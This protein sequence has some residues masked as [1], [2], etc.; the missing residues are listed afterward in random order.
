MWIYIDYEVW[1]DFLE[2]METLSSENY[3]KMIE[4]SRKSDLLIT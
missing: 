1:K 4:K 3:L 2:D